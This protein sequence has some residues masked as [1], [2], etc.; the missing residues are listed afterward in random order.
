MTV[1]NVDFGN[2]E[3]DLGGVPRR[4]YATARP[5]PTEYNW[6]SVVADLGE[7]RLV[8]HAHELE[9]VLGDGAGLGDQLQ[10]DALPT[11]PPLIARDLE[12]NTTDGAGVR[13]RS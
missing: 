1:D 2:G 7:L 13:I 5:R 8:R 6:L 4:M 10:V 12:V 11:A 9:H 3:G